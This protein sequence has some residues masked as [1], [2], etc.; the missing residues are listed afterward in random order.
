[1]KDTHW[2][3][4]RKILIVVLGLNWFVSAFKLVFGYIVNS[5]S[6]IADGYHS[7]SDGAS[8]IIGIIGIW[9]ASFPRDKEHPYGHKKYETFASIGIAILLLIVCFGILHESFSRFFDPVIPEITIF[10][11][12][13]MA[14]TML[15]NFG[16]MTFEYRKG[17]ALNSDIL[18]ADSM[19]TKADILISFSVIASFIFIKMGYPIV[20][21]I[22][23]TIIAFFIGHAG[24]EILRCSSK[25]LCDEAVIDP[26]I[27]KKIVSSVEGVS[28]CHKIRTRGR[29]DDIHIDLHVLLDDNMPLKTAHGI[30]YAIEKSIKQQIPG[31]S[32]VVV[33]LEPLSSQYSKK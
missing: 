1:M 24:L 13:I 14:V 5:Q 23:A 27:V 12:V 20:D 7:F 6:M 26:A 15:I 16:V 32:D 22:F 11:F 19:H 8:N 30:S 33:H 10:S 3:D 18:I 31:V 17:K 28:H 29:K 4:I 9:Y 21:T 25:V 2:V